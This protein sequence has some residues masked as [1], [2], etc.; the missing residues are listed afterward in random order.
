MTNYITNEIL[1]YRFHIADYFSFKFDKKR[2]IL[3]IYDAEDDNFYCINTFRKKENGDYN[4]IVT[5]RRSF[6][7]EIDGKDVYIRIYN[8]DSNYFDNKGDLYDRK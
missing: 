1:G 6:L 4:L 3:V 2:N 5:A 7:H 8:F